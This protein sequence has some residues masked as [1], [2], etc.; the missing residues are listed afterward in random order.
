M[1][2]RV[3]FSQPVS[4]THSQEK[5]HASQNYNDTHEV[6]FQNKFAGPVPQFKPQ[7]SRVDRQEEEVIP[8]KNLHKRIHSIGGEQAT[9]KFQKPSFGFGVAS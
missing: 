4:H 8:L 7:H 5:E 2:P 9:D 1:N 6:R 3:V